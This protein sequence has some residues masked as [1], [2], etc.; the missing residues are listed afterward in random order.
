MPHL[1]I[2]IPR[3][4]MKKKKLLRVCRVKQ[5]L[6]FKTFLLKKYIKI[7]FYY[8]IKFLCVQFRNNFSC[9]KELSYPLTYTWHEAVSFKK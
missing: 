5:Q 3:H 8:L 1:L 4:R 2:L 9:E 7:I 6:F